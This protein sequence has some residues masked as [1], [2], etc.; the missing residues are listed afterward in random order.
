MKRTWLGRGIEFQH[1]P[2]IRALLL[3]LLMGRGS[4]VLWLSLIIIPLR[5][6]GILASVL[7]F[8][9]FNLHTCGVLGEI[10]LI[11]RIWRGETSDGEGIGVGVSL[12]KLY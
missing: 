11:R 4:L 2:R 12:S 1:L 7:Y 3:R 5:V 10:F 9:P 8:F 6:C